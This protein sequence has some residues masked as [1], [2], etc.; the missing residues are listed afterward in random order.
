MDHLHPINIIVECGS[1]RT[2]LSFGDVVSLLGRVACAKLVQ[3]VLA[4]RRAQAVH[5]AHGKKGGRGIEGQ[6]LSPETNAVQKSIHENAF[7]FGEE[8]EGGVGEAGE[9]GRAAGSPEDKPER[10]ADYL[11]TRLGD[12]KS[13][14][15][16]ELV[17]REVPREVIRDALT[18]AL[19]VPPS[20][21]RRSRAALFTS[22]VRPHL[23]HGPRHH[24]ANQTP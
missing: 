14:A 19:D 20:K 8:S 7:A 1:H 10:I 2:E 22:I 24:D 13:L 6:D 17:A 4:S 12:E 15:F 5:R 9:G 23:G 16:Y 11:A 3:V 21:L 18:R